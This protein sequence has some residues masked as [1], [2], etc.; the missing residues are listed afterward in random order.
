MNIRKFHD[1][2]ID[3]VVRLSQQVHD[4]HVAAIRGRYKNPLDAT[5]A[6]DFFQ[7]YL[8]A[9]DIYA[10]VAVVEDSAIG[11]LVAE[12]RTLPEN[13]FR[14]AVRQFELTQIVVDGGKRGSGTGKALFKAFEKQAVNLEADELLVHTLDFNRTAH[15]FF[16]SCGFRDL[17]RNLWLPL[18]N[19]NVRN[20]T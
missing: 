4:Q 10:W 16:R 15:E 9:G 13:P 19:D 7:E 20:N 14:N 18:H 3:D 2:D 17:S 12:F 6:R 11:Y 1:R 5:E 8:A